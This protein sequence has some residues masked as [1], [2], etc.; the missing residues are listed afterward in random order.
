MIWRCRP[1][2]GQDVAEVG[3]LGLDLGG[4]LLDP[5]PLQ[6][7]Q[8]A[9]LQVEDRHRLDLVDVQQLHQPG[10]GGVGRRRVADQRDDGVERVQR[11]EVARAGCAPAPRPCAAGSG[12]AGR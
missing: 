12:C 4:L 11:L 6:R 7:G 2:L 9:Q 3:D 5:Q 1:R 10:A 8:P